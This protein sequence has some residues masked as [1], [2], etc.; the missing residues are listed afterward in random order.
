MGSSEKSSLY[1]QALEER[2]ELV[3][4]IYS[5]RK[6]LRQ[7][8]VLQDKVCGQGREQ[9]GG[10]ACREPGTHLLPL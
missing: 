9:G 4:T 6:Q 1:V 5:L 2:Q 8:E 7:A 10:P 3:E